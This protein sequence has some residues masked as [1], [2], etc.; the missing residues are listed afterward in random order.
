MN[1]NS[2]TRL[3]HSFQSKA[4]P[5]IS[6]YLWFIFFDQVNFQKKHF[7]AVCIPGE[8]LG[9]IHIC[10]DVSRWLIDV[11]WLKLGPYIIQFKDHIH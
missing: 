3:M 7:S 9:F 6:F 4:A 11:Y 2:K 10:F 5:F 8:P 1:F